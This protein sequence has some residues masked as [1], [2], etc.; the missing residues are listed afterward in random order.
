MANN[1]NT[2]KTGKKE[3]SIHEYEPVIGLTQVSKGYTPT[4][5]ELNEK[6]TD[7]LKELG[8]DSLDRVVIALKPSS[9]NASGIDQ[10]SINAYFDPKSGSSVF[11]RSGRQNMQKGKSFNIIAAAGN[12]G[13]GQFGTSDE[14]K[15]TMGPLC[16]TDDNGAAIIRLQKQS[17]QNYTMAVLQLDMNKTFRYMLGLGNDNRVG[18][19]ILKADHVGKDN[20]MLTIDTFVNGSSYSKGVRTSI[21]YKEVQHDILRSMGKQGGRQY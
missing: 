17:I 16:P 8:V 10:I 7:K 9:S 5:D 15:S 3:F 20:Y 13:S 6:L 19:R 1:N 2:T 4:V 14:F 21:N 18:Y 11:Y 12:G